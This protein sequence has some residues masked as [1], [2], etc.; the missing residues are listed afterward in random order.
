[1]IAVN[2]SDNYGNF[3]CHGWAGLGRAGP[4]FRLDCC[5]VICVLWQLSGKISVP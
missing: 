4:V 5:K 3:T 1:M 2:C